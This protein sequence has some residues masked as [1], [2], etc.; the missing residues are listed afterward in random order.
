MVT[1]G[2]TTIIPRLAEGMRVNC[3]LAGNAAALSEFSHALEVKKANGNILI[4][5]S[6]ELHFLS[7]VSINAWASVY[8]DRGITRRIVEK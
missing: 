3:H 6:N 8:N 4:N 7:S 5:L 2:A 1:I